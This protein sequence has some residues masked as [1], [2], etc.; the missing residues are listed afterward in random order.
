MDVSVIIPVYNEAATVEGLIERVIGA[1]L[2]LK[3]VIVV[4]DGSSDGTAEVLDEVRRRFPICR[5]ERHDANRGKGAAIRTALE[6]ARG[7]IV[8][9]QD[10]DPEYDPAEL[11]RLVEPIVNGV[12]DVVLGSRFSG[13]GL[14]RVG[15]FWHT[16][17]NRVLTLLSNML[18]NLALTDMECCY[19]LFRREVIETIRLEENRFGFEPEIIAKIARR[20]LR[21][22]E[23]GISYYGRTYAEGKK[24]NWKDG[25]RAI[26]CIFKYNLFRRSPGSPGGGAG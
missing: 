1:G 20:D 7:E 3:E 10:A 6:R 18:T 15:F 25:I 4:D 26:V 22:Y 16:L 8:I 21:I 9:I 24:I 5:I 17:A 13:G 14:H 19:K 12:A 2:P 11:P 23:V